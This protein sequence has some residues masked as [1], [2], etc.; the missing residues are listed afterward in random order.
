MACGYVLAPF[1]VYLADRFGYRTTAIV[2]S[3]SGFL[4]FFLASFSPTLWMMY[5]T[6]GLLGG[7]GH[8]T[9]YNASLLVVLQHF[10]KRRSVAVGFISSAG[11]VA[12][13]A[14]TQITQALLDAFG[15]RWAVRGFACLYLICGLSSS[16]YL[17]VNESQKSENKKDTHNSSVMRDRSFLVFSASTTI[18]VLSYYIPFV[19]IVSFIFRYKNISLCILFFVL[20]VNLRYE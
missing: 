13:F 14:I 2:G 6:F 17:P 20:Y 8:R 4:G 1:S 3:L 16:V 11:S 7:F 10:A 9:V 12:M 18:V 5:P 19:H 15:W